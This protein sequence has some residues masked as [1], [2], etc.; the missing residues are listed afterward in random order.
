MLLAIKPQLPICN[1]VHSK[2]NP[3]FLHLSVCLSVSLNWTS[4]QS[5]DHQTVQYNFAEG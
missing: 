1:D 5:A 4:H 3:L 2:V